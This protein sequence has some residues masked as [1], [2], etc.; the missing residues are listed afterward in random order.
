MPQPAASRF[1]WLATMPTGVRMPAPRRLHVTCWHCGDA[2]EICP[3]EPAQPEC[4][5]CE[6]LRRLYEATCAFACAIAARDHRAY[7][8]ALGR[9]R[10]AGDSAVRLLRTD[11][12]A[13]APFWQA[14]DRG[15]R[16][17]GV[18]LAVLRALRLGRG[19]MTTDAVD[20]RLDRGWPLRRAALDAFTLHAVAAARML[21]REREARRARAVALAEER[22][23]RLTVRSYR[24]EVRI[25][26]AALEAAKGLDLTGE[27]QRRMTAQIA[28]LPAPSAA[29]ALERAVEAGRAYEKARRRLSEVWLRHALEEMMQVPPLPY[30]PPPPVTE[31]TFRVLYV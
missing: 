23:P 17:A 13:E 22:R 14:W 11:D 30:L 5:R 21:W 20:Y 3:P 6:G 12:A 31:E 2:C 26:V 24:A 27:L 16:I 29:A 8:A 7:A 4:D 25:P 9:L 19:L 18:P 15:A 10:A 1:D 28:A